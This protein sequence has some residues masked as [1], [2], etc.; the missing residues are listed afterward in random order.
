MI[1]KQVTFENLTQEEADE[2]ITWM[3]ERM[4]KDLVPA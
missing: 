1:Q 4:E 3:Q 2:R